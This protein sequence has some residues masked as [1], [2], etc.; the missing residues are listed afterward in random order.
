MDNSE[1]TTEQIILEAA[2]AEFFEKGYG[3]TKTVA[4]AKRAGVSHSMLHYYFRKKENLFQMIFLKKVQ[5][6]AQEFEGIFIQNLPFAETVRLI[7]E[8]QFDFARQNPRLPYFILSEV[9]SNKEN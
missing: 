7:V 1:L 2:E 4:I 5:M 6:I 9:L 3:N 8:M